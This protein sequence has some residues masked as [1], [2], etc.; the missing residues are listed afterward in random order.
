MNINMHGERKLPVIPTTPDYEKIPTEKN[1]IVC[2]L[3]RG[4]RYNLAD[5]RLSER[6]PVLPASRSRRPSVTSAE[7]H[8]ASAGHKAARPSADIV[9]SRTSSL[10]GSA[11]D[12]KT[13]AS[14]KSDLLQSATDHN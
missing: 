10:T 3:S 14:L 7:G 12:G 4:D 8:P 9:P 11:S 5:P 1:K 2:S 13:I 6:E